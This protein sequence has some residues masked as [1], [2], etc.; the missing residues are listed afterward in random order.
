MAQL[1]QQGATVLCSHGGQAQP[2]SPNPRV[3][4]SG[5]AAISL[6]GPWTVSGCPFPP[7]SGG[8]CTTASWTSGTVRVTSSGQPLV[9]SSGSAT[10]TPTGVP[11]TVAVT[12][13]RV[14]AT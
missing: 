7:N 2:G 12:Q 13:V 1:V 14:S 11:L 6:S 8:P 4:L 10:C 9:L 5:S 3:T